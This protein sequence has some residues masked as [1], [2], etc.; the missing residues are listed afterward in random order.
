MFELNVSG[1]RVFAI[2]L[3]I[4]GLAAVSA[5]AETV[6]AVEY[7]HKDFEHYFVTANPQEITLLDGGVFKGWWRTGQRYRVDDSP[8]PDLVPVCRFLLRS[9]RVRLRISTPRRPPNAST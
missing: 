7:Y 9:M 2:S 6:R 3:A 4:F 8:A 1:I 5:S